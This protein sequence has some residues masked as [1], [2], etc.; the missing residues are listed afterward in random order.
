MG[1]WGVEFS[2][3]RR[4]GGARDR[5]MRDR[6]R[7][8]SRENSSCKSGLASLRGGERNSSAQDDT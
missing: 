7:V 4:V 1:A 3:A 6:A 2:S 8:R 5:E